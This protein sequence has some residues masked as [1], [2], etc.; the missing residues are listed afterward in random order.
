MDYSLL[1]VLWFILVGVL[2]I[3]YAILDGFDLGIGALMP[4]LADGEKEQRILLNAVGP[5]WD[6]NEVWLLTGGGA[7]FAAF[8]HV[9]ATIFSGF[10]IALMLVLLALI[11]RAAS[12]EFYAHDEP[13]RKIWSFAFSLGSFL[14]A[15]LFGVALGNVIT[16]LPLDATNWEYSGK[17]IGLLGIPALDRF[18]Y[19]LRPFPLVIGLVGLAA[20]LS[21]G[22]TYA[23]LKTEGSMKDKAQSVAGKIWIAYVALLAVAAVLAQFCLEDASGKVLSWVALVITIGALVALKLFISKGSELS[24]FLASS[25]AFL[26]LWGMVG[27]YLFPN[28]VINNLKGGENITI[29]NSSSSQLTLTVMLIIALIGVPIMLGYTIYAY[30]IFKGKTILT[31]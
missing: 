26:G 28:L 31:D 4:F 18:I 29:F 3:G 10:Y 20:I 14:P 6:G 13:N 5:V 17:T 16:G 15:L 27:G 21:Q 30:R 24:A 12:M 19:L 11:F 25:V 8:P 7:I 2:L 23:M 22:A 1:Q 9:Y